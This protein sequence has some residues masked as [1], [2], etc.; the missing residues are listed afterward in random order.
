MRGAH[1]CQLSKQHTKMITSHRPPEMTAVA[2][3]HVGATQLRAR[4]HRGCVQRVPRASTR[5][6]RPSRLIARASEGAPGDDAEE[7]EE[8]EV[9]IDDLV[10]MEIGG[11]SVS[12]R[13][14]VALLVPKGSAGSIPRAPNPVEELRRAEPRVPLGSLRTAQTLPLLISNRPEDR[15]GA[16]SEWA[17][18]M[19]QLT[20]DPPIDMGIQ[21]PYGALDELTGAEGSILGAVFLGEARWDDT[22][23]RYVF[24]S[25]LLAGKDLD[26]S[27]Y[28]LRGGEDEAWR[29]LALALRYAPY[30]CR[31]F[32]TKK[33][34]AT[35][36]A[37]AF[38]AAADHE[39]EEQS[40]PPGGGLSFANLRDAFPMLQT[41]KE[42][43]AIAAEARKR[44]LLDP[45]MAASG[46]GA[47]QDEDDGGSVDDDEDG[48]TFSK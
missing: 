39:Y 13:G 34:L 2:T 26:Q 30:G 28:D 46:G 45:F 42:A 23:T 4:L 8:E 38:G 31:I 14:F 10:E 19:L 25:T 16:A 48:G 1:E 47:S 29:A 41:T 11:V 6:R 35:V 15:E 33:A 12:P 5:T 18:A 27:T 37:R 43:R 3:P 7:E 40:A 36:D 17:Q 20:Q 9:G 24:E 44:Y 22:G 21:L 32:A